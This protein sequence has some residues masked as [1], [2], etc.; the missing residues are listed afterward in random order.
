MT[1]IML[2]VAEFE[3]AKIVERLRQGARM[4]RGDGMGWWLDQL[5]GPRDRSHG[6]ARGRGVAPG[7]SARLAES[8][9]LN[10]RARPYSA[11]SVADMLA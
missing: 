3:K 6:D 2:A 4:H 5:G 8:G 10:H 7:Y 9:M 1:Q 11:Q